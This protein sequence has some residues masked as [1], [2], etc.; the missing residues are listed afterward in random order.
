MKRTIFSMFFLFLAAPSILAGS[1]Q[2]A[3]DLYP[4]AEQQ[5]NIFQSDVS[6][7]QLELDFTAQI[8]VPT[9][10]HLTLKWQ[11]EDRWWRRVTMGDFQQIE[12]RNGD[13]LYT[14]NNAG[15]TP[16][17]VKEL[18]GLIQFAKT[19]EGV[20]L[21][22]VKQRI[23]EGA[24]V[25]CFE[26]ERKSSGA[27]A[28]DLCINSTSRDIVW[29]EWKEFAEER[30]KHEYSSYFDF[31]RHRYPREMRLLVNGI[32]G[33]SAHVN[34]LETA[35]LDDAL[36]VPP[37]GALERRQCAG[38]KHPVAIKTPDPVYPRSAGENGMMGITSAAVTVLADGSI[39]DVQLIG[40][41]TRS[42]DEATLQA[43]KNWKFKPA[44]CGSEP[45]VSDIQVTVN[46][47]LY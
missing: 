9:S 43:L 38:M 32:K 7:F 5:A 36:L 33:L 16:L 29:D 12:I 10:G 40:S 42:M 30:R 37:T 13:R 26:T 4:A 46:F 19:P 34:S 35:A 25:T 8:Q 18:F 41:G 6:P 1:D 14:K 27:I 47:R 44:M 39:G 21:K 22:K 17:R 23:E 2:G 15:F 31:G 11:A 20:K 3:R 45:V 28:H 24:E